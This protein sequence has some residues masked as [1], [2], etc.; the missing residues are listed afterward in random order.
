MISNENTLVRSEP[1]LTCGAMVLWTQS[2]W[3]DA[4]AT[5]AVSRAAY[6][7]VNGHLV[8]P[9][10]TPQCPECGIHDTAAASSPDHY[11][12]RRCGAIFQRAT[13]A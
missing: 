13:R 9:K 1:C 10:Q 2:A 11:R 6:K 4:D 5:P 7:C 12:C 8:D 3:I